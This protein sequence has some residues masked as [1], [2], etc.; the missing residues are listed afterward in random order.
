MLSGDKGLFLFSMPVVIACSLIA[1]R[2]VSMTFIP[3]I[4]VVLLR[5]GRNAGK[6]MEEIRS[7]G[8]AGFYYRLGTWLIDHRWKVLAGSLVLVVLAFVLKSQLKD[9]FFPYDLSH[10]SYIDVWLP[11]DA[12]VQASDNTARQ[13]EDIV[14]RTAE[15]YG[16]T[17]PGKNAE[18]RDILKRVTSFV[19]ASGPR[20]WFS[21]TP[22]DGKN[23]SAQ[24]LPDHHGVLFSG[25]RSSAI[26]DHYLSQTRSEIVRESASARIPHRN[27][28]RI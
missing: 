7:R 8:F 14:R 6:S 9:Q 10:L 15:E 19:G 28:R 5:P 23:R 1:S 3:L 27:R 12:P 2:I 24:S 25:F 13:V 26:R 22:G 11:E 20:F 17:H 4:G 18:I 16:A 21:V